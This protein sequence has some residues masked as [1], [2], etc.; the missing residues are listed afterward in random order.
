[1]SNKFSRI[2]TQ[3]INPTFLALC[4]KLVANCSVLGYDYYAISGY[5]SP[6]EQ[7]TIYAQGRTTPGKIVTNAPPFSSLHQFGLAIDF[8][9]DQDMTKDGLQPSW[10][11]ADYELLATEARKLGLVCGMDFKKFKE[12]PHIQ[13][14]TNK[15]LSQLT[16]WFKA[17]GLENVWKNL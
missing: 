6:E 11:I 17:G 4:E 12:G 9:K 1:M 10:N 15:Q 2:N 5:R 3:K 16:D 13:L 8:C 14:A 7:A